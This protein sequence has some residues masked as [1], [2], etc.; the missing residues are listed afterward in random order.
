MKSPTDIA[1]SVRV[2][3]D[4]LPTVV[5]KFD[6]QIADLSVIERNER[7]LVDALRDHAID[8]Y[9]RNVHGRTGRPLEIGQRRALVE[10]LDRA[11]PGLVAGRN[12]DQ[13]ASDLSRLESDLGP[14]GLGTPEERQLRAEV[15]ALRRDLLRDGH[16]HRDHDG[17]LRRI[18]ALVARGK[19]AWAENRIR[20]L[21]RYMGRD[22]W[23]LR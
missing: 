7:H 9:D 12:A 16:Y 11:A 4:E 23:W 21:E 1:A 15:D 19:G 14:S 3:A 20:Y 5:A 22:R 2:P 10:L 17:P 8:W 13:L 18:A 6:E